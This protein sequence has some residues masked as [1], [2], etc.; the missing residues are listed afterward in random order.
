MKN[1]IL[2][3]KVRAKLLL[4]FGSI[5]LFSVILVVLS[6]GSIHK[7]IENKVVNEKVEKLN[8]TIQSQE[9]AIKEF[10]YEG[11]KE[12]S[13]QESG[14]S[15]SLI[16][17]DSNYIKALSILDELKENFQD[18]ASSGP[19]VNQIEQV[20]LL[21]KT[22]FESLKSS[23]RERG[24]KDYGLEGSLRRAVHKIE[25][26][27]IKFDKAMLLT[28]RRNEKDFFLRRDLKYQTDFISNAEIFRNTILKIK[29][30]SIPEV[31]KN[32]DNYQ[33]EFLKIIDLETKIGLKQDQGI[34]GKLNNQLHDLRKPLEWFSNSLKVK[35]ERQI[36]EIIMELWIVFS[37]QLIVG[38]FLALFY[39]DLITKSIKEI[40][41]AVQALANGVFPEKLAVK[42]T[43]EIGQTKMAVNQFL[44]RLETAT[45]FA[46]KM[47]EG[48]LQATYDERFD[49]D[50][51]AKSII[52]MQKKLKEAD[53]KQA[54]INWV[55]M[56]AVKFSEIIKNEAEDI[57]TL[58][59][60]I[61][62]LLVNYLEANQGALYI[63]DSERLLRISTYA[64]GKKKFT[65]NSIEFGQGLVG[66]CAIEGETIYLKD[67]PV[68]Y[69]KITS[70]LGEATPR[71]VLII[72]IKQKERILGVLE[73][74]SFETVEKHKIEFVEK[75]SES[76]ASLI[77]NKQN[78]SQTKQLLRES[79]ERAE[80][81]SQQEEEMRQNAEELQAT[82]EE[83]IRQ[84]LEL[85]MQIVSL[86]QKLELQ[87]S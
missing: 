5:L 9:L 34:R 12:T 28:L 67:I 86:K 54:K 87:A 37:I 63:I 64:Y 41:K 62:A 30:P 13:F 10:I 45:T 22:E 69:V 17:Y 32:L 16:A 60:K 29:D 48:Q 8:L 52:Q 31:L 1:W 57:A 21:I 18:G 81:L 68:D 15:S 56:G 7:V 3:L 40:K 66:Q 83:M 24:F 70:G 58:A 25:E 33:S 82:Q 19:T 76:I 11:F 73:L 74:A 26:C 61:L 77:F 47:G 51:L 27:N 39:A 23:L 6:I 35:S 20:L 85:E 42:T 14:K 36:S 50:V 53:E 44:D 59:D 79:Q 38:A 72:P 65:E 43:E 55:N 2:A 4:A 80:I 46:R 75:I 49:N 78:A 71:N 84:K